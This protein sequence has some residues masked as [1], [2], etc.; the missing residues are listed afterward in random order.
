MLSHLSQLCQNRL[1]N[2]ETINLSKQ[3]FINI[4]KI[5]EKFLQIPMGCYVKVKNKEI[6]TVENAE[7]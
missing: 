2:I 1:G 7:M 3:I 4:I 5:N 6:E